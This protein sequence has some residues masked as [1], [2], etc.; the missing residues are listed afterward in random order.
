[1]IAI[2][3]P[4]TTWTTS[5]LSYTASRWLEAPRWLG[6]LG[7]LFRYVGGVWSEYGEGLPNTVGHDV[8]WNA[9]DDV[10]V[11]GTFGRGAWSIANASQTINDIS[12]L[13]IT[14][15][16]NGFA[17]DDTIRLVIDAANPSL[18]D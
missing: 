14:G 15:D 11:V 13:V 6:G 4:V 1:M 12:A 3:C 18:L 8:Q 9:A 7:G 10:L 2:I 5:R 16:E 17:E